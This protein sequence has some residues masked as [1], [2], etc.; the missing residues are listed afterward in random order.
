MEHVMR[1][2]C[3]TE[4]EQQRRSYSNCGSKRLFN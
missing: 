4:S 1:D 3:D 2:L